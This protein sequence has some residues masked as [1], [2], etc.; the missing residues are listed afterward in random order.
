VGFTRNYAQKRLLG[1]LVSA[2]F[3]SEDAARQTRAEETESGGSQRDEFHNFSLQTLRDLLP[4]HVAGARGAAGHAAGGACFGSAGSGN[5]FSGGDTPSASLL[6]P[7]EKD[8]VVR[9]LLAGGARSG[10]KAAAAAAEQA[11]AE[12]LFTGVFV[13]APGGEARR[14]RTRRGSGGDK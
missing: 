2:H 6:S 5:G 12:Q 11:K 13:P 1:A 7:R 14:A 3:F 8:A 9:E 10:N 4:D